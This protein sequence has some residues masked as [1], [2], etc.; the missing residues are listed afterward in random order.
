[1]IMWIGLGGV[2]GAMSRYAIGWWLGKKGGRFPWAT[3]LVNASGSLLL[4]WLSAH[5][6]QFPA[7]VYG[8][9]GIGFC[10]AFTTFST[11][12]YESITLAGNKRYLHAFLYVMITL[13]LGFAGAWAG[14]YI[15]EL[16]K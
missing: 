1:M 14:F 10:G 3:L 9:L 15:S 4:G 2:M 12:G 6:S 8:I 16:M 7:A 11:F 5:E 13:V